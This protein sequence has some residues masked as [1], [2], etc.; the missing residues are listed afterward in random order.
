MRQLLKQLQEM[1]HDFSPSKKSV[2]EYILKH[3]SDI[4]F[5][6]ISQVAALTSTSEATITKLCK[7]LGF[8]GF[9]ELKGLIG[10]HVNSTLTMDSKLL[11]VASG[12]GEGA[13]LE[14]TLSNEVLNIQTTLRNEENIKAIPVSISMIDSASHVYT[15]GSRTSAFF[16]G[17]FAFKLRQQGINVSHIEWGIGDYIEKVM[18][19]KPGDLVIAFSFARFTKNTVKVLRVLKEKHISIILFTGEGLSP[20]YEY[21]DLVFVCRT[22]FHSYV[23]SYTACLSLINAILAARAVQHKEHVETHLRELEA[24][25]ELFDIFTG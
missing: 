6:T 1:Q 20:A 11:R 22:D 7:E 15:I 12:L 9:S 17:L 10:Q 14:S 23:A 16:A 25:F 3:Y 5:Q 2:A 24:N 19:I 4:P 21:A 8:T 13:L 18:M